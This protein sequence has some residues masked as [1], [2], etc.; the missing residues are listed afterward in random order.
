[1]KILAVCTPT[2]KGGRRARLR[3]SSEAL[4]KAVCNG[5]GEEPRKDI[6][7]GFENSSNASENHYILRFSSPLRSSEILRKTLLISLP[8]SLSLIES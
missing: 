4:R 1:M 6:Y 7:R 2:V 8:C 3:A 5:T